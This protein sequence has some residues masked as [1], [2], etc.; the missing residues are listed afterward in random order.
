MPIAAELAD[1]RW[2]ACD[3]SPRAWTVVR[4]QFEKQ[5]NLGIETEGGR[6]DE[7]TW[8][9]L[10]QSKS[11][12]RVRGPNDLPERLIEGEPIEASLI[13]PPKPV[14]RRTALETSQQIWEAFVAEWGLEC[15]YCGAPQ[16]RDRR[17]LQLDHVE[18][19]QW[20]GSNDDCWNR[21]LACS[22]CNSDKGNRL[23]A[24]EA[25]KNALKV[26]R[27]ESERRMVEQIQQVQGSSRIGPESLGGNG[28]ASVRAERDGAS[29]TGSH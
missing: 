19:N 11:T 5:R 15:W 20:D 2:I 12:T 8:L 23:S 26:Q 25:I 6:H 28:Q 24:E 29:M 14:F 16:Q 9:R 18:P 7:D 3:M 17:M 10:D 1:R 22:P 13:I 21:A 27:I 4:R